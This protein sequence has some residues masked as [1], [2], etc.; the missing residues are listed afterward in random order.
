MVDG[1]TCDARHSAPNV[2]AALLEKELHPGKAISLVS[3]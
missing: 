3:V 1:A 2:A